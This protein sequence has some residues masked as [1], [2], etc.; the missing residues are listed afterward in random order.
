V[1]AGRPASVRTRQPPAAR[2]GWAEVRAWRVRRHHLDERRPAANLLAVASDIA[3]LH[4]QVMSSAEL[5]LW[6]RLDGMPLDGVQR[7]LWR[8]RTLVKTWAMRG[9]LH[10]LPAAEYPLWQAALSTRRAYE[11]PVWLRGFGITAAELETLLAA[12]GRAL[13]GPPLTREELADAVTRITGS[14]A[15]GERVRGSWG[16]FLKPAASLGLLCF[17]PGDGQLVRFTRPDRW[18]GGW[19][20]E[21]P[22]TALAWATRRF[23]TAAGPVTR[24]ELARWWGVQPA[25]GGRMLRALGDDV[26]PVEVDG[27]AAWALA[28]DVAAIGAAPPARTVRLLPAFD[29]YVITATK[30]VEYL[31]PGPYGERI[32]RAQ[33]WISPVLLVDGR[34]DGVWRHEVKGGR[35]SVR[36]EP[37]G[38]VPARVRRAAAQEAERLAA[39]IGGALELSWD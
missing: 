3:G 28:G 13:D 10:L 30:Q 17:G 35:V 39:H 26:I 11:K 23:L 20:A 38:T 32:Y 25:D 21:D 33:G 14:A 12:I 5:T 6:A 19:Q 36:I 15:Q 24:E 2:L 29:Q 22:A 16:G 4:A 1:A 8:D 18:L 27:V 37:F 34:M 9:T 7:A 31:T